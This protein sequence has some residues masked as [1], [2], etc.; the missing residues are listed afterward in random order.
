MIGG[1]DVTLGTGAAAA[2]Y[3]LHA[4]ARDKAGNR[5]NTLPQTFVHDGTAAV[6]TAPAVLG[7]SGP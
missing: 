7:P 4:R 1:M 5:S 6:A 2:Y 3:R